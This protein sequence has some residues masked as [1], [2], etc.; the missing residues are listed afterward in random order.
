[1]TPSSTGRRF[2]RRRPMRLLL[3]LLLVSSLTAA[4]V[5]VAVDGSDS[6]DGNPG[7]PLA[8]VGAA[9]DAAR[10]L[11]A[12][13][14]AEPVIVVFGDGRF[15]LAEPLRITPGDSGL[16]LQARSPGRA[17]L[18]GGIRLT[19]WTAA[20]N[21]HEPC[22]PQ[23]HRRPVPHR[24]FGRL[25][26]GLRADALP[27]QREQRHYRPVR[28]VARRQLE[29]HHQPVLERSERLVRHPEWCG[30]HPVLVRRSTVVRLAGAWA[31]PA[32]GHRRPAARGPGAT[33]TRA[34]EGLARVRPGLPAD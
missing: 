26:L 4:T 16:T 9:L 15:E 3:P 22:C 20:S 24:H 18:S 11:K 14:P 1:M 34:Q 6:G 13:N 28:D 29:R 7:S 19:G 23:P 5:R 30:C 17:V 12:A 10:R 31:G 25:E 33:G 32:F 21:R 2:R 27:C 8:S